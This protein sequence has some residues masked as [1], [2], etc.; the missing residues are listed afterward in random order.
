MADAQ[1]PAARLDIDIL[2]DIQRWLFTYPPLSHDRR[3]IHISVSG[4]IATVS[5]NIK[6]PITRDYLRKHIGEVQ[7]VH[8]IV[9]GELYD[10]DTI[11]L[12]LGN[13]LEP[14]ALANPEWG[15]VVLSGKLP[16]G[17]AL[18]ALVNRVGQIAGV[19][20]VVAVEG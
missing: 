9:D 3:H 19:H 2:A 17:E 20:K 6:T 16:D 8:E 13:L 10:D 11:R 14:G 15:M 12:A 18:Q 7:G 4:G 1:T 5:G